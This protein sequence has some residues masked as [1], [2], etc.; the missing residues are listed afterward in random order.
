MCMVNLFCYLLCLGLLLLR[1][2]PLA[3]FDVLWQLCFV[4]NT[5]V[6]FFVV[7]VL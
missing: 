5:V 3:L 4:V 1:C 7:R 2:N 6:V